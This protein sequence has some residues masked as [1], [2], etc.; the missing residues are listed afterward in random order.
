M[1]ETSDVPP[2]SVPAL[3]ATQEALEPLIGRLDAAPV[4]ALDTEFLRES[5]Y[6]AQLCLLQ[7]GMPGEVAC[8]DPLAGLELTRFWQVVLRER[9]LML[10][11]AA[12]Q[13]LELIRQHTGA[14]PASLFDTQV[15]AALLGHPAQLGYAGL[16]ERLLGVQLDKSHARTDWSRRPLAAAKLAYAGDDV[17]YLPELHAQLGAELER[18]GRAAWAAED[19][20]SLLNPALYENPPETAWQRVKGLRRLQGR[21]R[22]AARALAAWRE[23][24]AERLDRP[25]RWVLSDE[26]L[27]ALA[28]ALPEDRAALDAV[29]G[30][31]PGLVRRRG[32]ALLEVVTGIPVSAPEETDPAPLDDAEKKTL[33]RLASLARELADQLDLEPEVLATRAELTSAVRGTPTGRPFVGWRLEVIG[34]QLLAAV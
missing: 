23:V 1:T 17:R 13:D 14:L 32:D 5:T 3:L 10:M 26:Q 20:E 28:D 18:R 31:P 27:L 12:R 24:T 11:H 19:C 4:V 9:P 8:I 30:L 2:G 22:A 25:R 6:F 29:P 33:A 21:A 34:R 7:V 15:A 16:V